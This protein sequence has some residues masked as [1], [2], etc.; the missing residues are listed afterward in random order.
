MKDVT[1]TELSTGT[2][3]ATY[4]TGATQVRTSI[5]NPNGSGS[6]YTSGSPCAVDLSTNFTHNNDYNLMILVRVVAANTG[7]DQVEGN[8]YGVKAHRKNH[9]SGRKLTWYARNDD[10][11]PGESATTATDWQDYAVS[12]AAL[13]VIR[14]TY[15]TY[16]ITAQAYPQNAGCTVKIDDGAAGTSVNGSYVYGTEHTITATPASGYTFMNWIDGSNSP[17]VNPYTVTMGAVD[18]TVTAYFVNQKT[19]T[20]WTYFIDAIGDVPSS[21]YTTDG[22]GNV[23]ISNEEGLA[24]LVSVVNGLNGQ[25][26]NKLSGKT[27]TLTADVN[28][29]DHNWVPI[30][31]AEHSFQG[32][33]EGNGHVIKGITRSDEFPH[34]G[35]FGYV[36]GTANIKDVVVEAALTG[37]SLATGAVVG[38]FASS[39]TISNVEGA[40]TLTGGALTTAIG[41]L[42]GN[43]TG[44]TI[45]SSFAVATLES[46][47]EAT[48]GGLVGTNTGNVYNS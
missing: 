12:D 10:S 1:D 21:G 7:G 38:T 41:G 48:M 30:G 14:W 8:S 46:D 24:W 28:M 9:G 44:G 18:R 26:A 42:V 19:S 40:G 17:I 2:S 13:P 34:N 47:H 5:I 20:D 31:T 29:S 22:D 43:K 4:K 35:L 6:R 3:F 36:D 23:T 32:T 45:H 11:D 33:F 27:I 15:T 37:N 25:T 39:G 16:S